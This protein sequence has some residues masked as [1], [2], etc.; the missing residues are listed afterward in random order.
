MNRS[1]VVPVLSIVL[2]MLGASDLAAQGGES[3][4]YVIGMGDRIRI[5]VWQ[6]PSLDRD[7]DVGVDSMIVL[8]LVGPIR[9]GGYSPVQLSRILTERFSLYKRDISQ[10][11][12]VVVEYNSREIFV[13]G[14]VAKRGR[15]TFQRIPDLW[16]V[17]MTAGGP[18]QNAFL[19]EVRILRGT[20]AN[21]NSI[22]VNLN[23]YLL[24]GGSSGL[25]SLQPG[26]TVYIP[27]ASTSGVD[28]FAT[29]VIYIYGK[30]GNP[31]L[32]LVGK[33]Q[34]LIGALLTAGG[35]TDDGD[36]TNIKVIREEGDRRIVNT[37]NIDDYME[38]GALHGNPILK[39]GDT[40]EVSVRR[41]SMVKRFI[42]ELIA[43]SF[44]TVTSV[45]ALVVLVDRLGD[46]RD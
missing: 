8:P 33:D 45:V 12:V 7:V 27:T 32:F 28:A 35:L 41:S 44:Q 34:D 18:T 40:I 17:I 25:P 30:V 43:P 23:T 19:G 22:L 2:L 38:R 1:I 16:T 3:G 26:D 6:E 37:V 29:S 46:D 14:E 31:G 10:V 42:Q 15:Y 13:I 11:E 39:P 4:A 20:G 24:G 5:S 9:A 21:E 36:P